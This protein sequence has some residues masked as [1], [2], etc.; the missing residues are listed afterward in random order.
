MQTRWDRFIEIISLLALNLLVSLR[1]LREYLQV[2]LR[3]YPQKTFRQ[4]HLTLLKSYLLNNPYHIHKKWL[5][6]QGAKDPYTYGETPLTTLEYIA[7]AAKITPKDHVLEMGCGRGTCVFW[8]RCIIGCK[9][10]GVDLV[11]TFIEKAQE[12]KLNGVEFRLE[13]ILHTNL[14]NITV[15]YFYGTSSTNPFIK[16]LI[17][18]LATLPKGSRIITVS[19]PLTP[20]T[21]KKLF[22]ITHKLPAKFTWGYTDVYIHTRL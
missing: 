21:K 8:L 12:I 14:N 19:Y 2:I 17:K 15:V 6:Q 1:Q 22:A 5:Q 13:D 18:K 3:Y 10:T 4:T 20:Y 7:K 11:P 16:A 9:A